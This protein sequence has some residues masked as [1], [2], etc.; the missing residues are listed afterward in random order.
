M[1]P[2][3]DFWFLASEKQKKGMLLTLTTEQLQFLTEVIH[4][5]AT[6]NIPIFEDDKKILS[7]HKRIISGVYY[8]YSLYITCDG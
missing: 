2:F 6:G 5:A 4:N 3:V 8:R 1:R 7:K